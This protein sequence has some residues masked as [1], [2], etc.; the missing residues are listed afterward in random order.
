MFGGEEMKRIAVCMM[1]VVFLGVGLVVI[2]GPGF[3]HTGSRGAL[4][5]DHQDQWTQFPGKKFKR[6]E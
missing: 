4:F 2:A 3:S 5:Y 6:K 1:L